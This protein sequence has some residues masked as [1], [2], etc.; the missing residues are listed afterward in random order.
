VK[1]EPEKLDEANPPEEA[2]PEER[3]TASRLLDDSLPGNDKA[4]VSF[5]SF[6]ICL[7]GTVVCCAEHG[8]TPMMI[9]RLSIAPRARFI[10]TSGRCVFAAT[11][12]IAQNERTLKNLGH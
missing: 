4:A 11:E 10:L 7:N 3:L 8:Q 5:A 2:N 6:S 1:P 9:A 12:C